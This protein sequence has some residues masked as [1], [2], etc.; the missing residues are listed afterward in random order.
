MNN[1]CGKIEIMHL[2]GGV[3]S[4]DG[5][6]EYYSIKLDSFVDDI[7]IRFEG[8]YAEKKYKSGDH[9][10]IEKIPGVIFLGEE[11]FDFKGIS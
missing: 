6:F 1:I 7:M 5:I 4:R 8:M 2:R 3:G 11:F 9:I 10:Y